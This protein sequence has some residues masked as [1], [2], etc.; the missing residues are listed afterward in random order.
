FTASVVPVVPVAMVRLTP[1]QSIRN[2]TRSAA[3][4]ISSVEAFPW[5]KSPVS[6]HNAS[7]NVA[8]A[9]GRAVVAAGIVAPTEARGATARDGPKVRA[10][11]NGRPIAGRRAAASG[12][13]AV[14]RKRSLSGRATVAPN[15]LLTENPRVKVYVAAGAQG[16][17]LQPAGQLQL[18]AT[19]AAIATQPVIKL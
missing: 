18:A 15:G 2:D 8:S 9:S 19:S 3:S 12:N 6:N 10:S 17:P 16:M 13:P 14:A 1:W 11:R 7:R 4:S 5:T